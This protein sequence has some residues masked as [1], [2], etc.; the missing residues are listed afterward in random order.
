M[1]DLVTGLQGLDQFPGAGSQPGRY[2]AGD[3]KAPRCMLSQ[4][5]GPGDQDAGVGKAS[6]ALPEGEPVPG[7]SLGL[8]GLWTHGPI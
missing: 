1:V 4:A 2:H 8:P 7:R 3:V 6:S 5:W